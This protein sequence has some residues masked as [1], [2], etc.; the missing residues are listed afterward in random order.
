MDSHKAHHSPDAS[1][2]IL[3][4]KVKAGVAANLATQRLASRLRRRLY[5]GQE[6]RQTREGDMK[7]EIESWLTKK[8]IWSHEC[9]GNTIKLTVEAAVK[10]GVSLNYANLNYA[11]LNYANLNYAELNY[12]ELN[13]AKLNYA[14]LN[15]AQLKSAQLNSAQLNSAELNNAE[16]NNCTGNTEQTHCL[17]HGKYKLVIVGDICHGGCTTMTCAEWLAYDGKNLDD[18]DKNYLETVTKPFIRMVKG[19]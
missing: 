12:A 10:A 8:V 7:I 15:D 19:A 6:F 17:Q 9:E 13:Y 2:F 3:G 18:Y 4:L 11:N 5:I 14:N 16:L 1:S